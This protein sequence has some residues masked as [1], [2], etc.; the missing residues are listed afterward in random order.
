MVLQSIPDVGVLRSFRLLAYT[1]ADNKDTEW[2]PE[3]AC[4]SKDLLSSEIK[5]I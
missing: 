5:R 4:R 3:E 2:D 1:A